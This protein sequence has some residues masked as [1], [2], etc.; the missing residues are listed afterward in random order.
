MRTDTAAPVANFLSKQ[1]S[2]QEQIK[3]QEILPLL[4]LPHKN[5][6]DV[7]NR[8]GQ[9]QEEEASGDGGSAKQ[10][11]TNRRQGRRRRPSPTWTQAVEETA[12][13]MAVA[14]GTR[15][16]VG[17]VT[18]DGSQQLAGGCSGGRHEGEAT[19]MA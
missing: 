4:Y 15:N 19:E 11:Q 10:Q 17:G 9:Q 1:I 12:A 3:L 18:G 14:N 8:A 13:G 5:W 6:K 16:E 2:P 7:Q